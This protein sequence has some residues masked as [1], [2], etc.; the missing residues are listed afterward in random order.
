MSTSIGKNHEQ[1]VENH[2]CGIGNRKNHE[3]TVENHEFGVGN[4]K[5]MKNTYSKKINVLHKVARG[6]EIM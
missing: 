3:K 2:E 1:S 4:R 6:E 5:I